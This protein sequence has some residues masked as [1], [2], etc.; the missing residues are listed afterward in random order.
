[1]VAKFGINNGQP[2]SLNIDYS[3]PDDILN[4]K[5]LIFNVNRYSK[6]ANMITFNTFGNAHFICNS[7]P[8][9][10]K[11]GFFIDISNKKIKLESK[12]NDNGEPYVDITGLIHV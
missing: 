1:M 8:E 6:N 11:W 2:L 12:D 5:I 10:A 4:Y 3:L 9:G 7:G